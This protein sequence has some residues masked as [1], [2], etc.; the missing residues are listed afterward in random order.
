MLKGTKIISA[1]VAAFLLNFNLSNTLGSE[2]NIHSQDL[3]KVEAK[4]LDNRA[5]I[6]QAYLAKYNS[7]LQYH[8]QDFIDAAD[9]NEMDWKWIPA[10]S[11]VES[12]F[13]KA[14]PNSSYNAWG[15]GASTPDKAIYFDS[16]TEAIFTIANGLKKNY[17]DKGLTNPYT[18]NKVYAA[19]PTWGTK[20][21]YFL[22]DLDKFSQTYSSQT[23]PRYTA[24]FT[25]VAGPSA[26][27]VFN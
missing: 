6:L 21:D 8:A 1:L 17:L 18:M 16:W 23:R 22:N 15:W 10:I 20:V 24:A 14:I 11:G 26:S 7:P 5:K 25:K 12:T 13:G 19:S 9:A 3:V 2:N 27:L 4:Q